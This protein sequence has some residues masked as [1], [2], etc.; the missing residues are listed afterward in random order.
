MREKFIL[1][2][3]TTGFLIFCY[4]IMTILESVSMLIMPPN[5]EKVMGNPSSY[6]G[7]GMMHE[8]LATSQA[9][10]EYMWVYCL[11]SIALGGLIPLC[12]GLYLMVSGRFFI[13]LCYPVSMSP[14]LRTEP[15]VSFQPMKPHDN[16]DDRKFMPPEMR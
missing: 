16:E 2:C 1:V 4:S 14:E 15:S 9:S 5:M 11:K 10:V 12:F 3:R 6:F 8:F 7:S 13:A